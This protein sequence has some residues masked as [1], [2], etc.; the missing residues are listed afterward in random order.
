MNI[1][2]ASASP[3]RKK[4]LRQIGLSFSVHP[5]AITEKMD[6]TLPPDKLV[7]LLAKQK[8]CDVGVLHPNSFIIAAD[9]VVW[10][11]GEILSKPE[12]TDHARE[13]LQRLSGRTHTVFSGVFL[14]T[15]NHEGTIT[16]PVSFSERT[17]VTFSTLSGHEVDRYI[18]TGSPMDKAGAYGIQDDAGAIFVKKIHG[19]YNNVVGFPLHS[20]YQHVKTSFP[21]LYNSYFTQSA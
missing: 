20:F 4:L 19:D 2:L 12:N 17:N 3:R 16:N 18:Q 9:T 21:D 5:S 10:F 14:C 13:M 1:V 6:S 7:R 11:E 15:T 8:G